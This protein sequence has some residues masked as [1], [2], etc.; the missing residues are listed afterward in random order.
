[1]ASLPEGPLKR[2]HVFISGISKH[3]LRLLEKRN[4]LISKVI[5]RFSMQIT[6]YF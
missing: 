1:M 2:K 6:Q 5:Y 3:A 4:N